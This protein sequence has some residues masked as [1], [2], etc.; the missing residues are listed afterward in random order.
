M[1][2]ITKNSR[3]LS[4]KQGDISNQKSPLWMALWKVHHGAPLSW[5]Y[6]NCH[7]LCAG[8]HIQKGYRAPT[9]D[10]TLPTAELKCESGDILPRI[11]TD[12]RNIAYGKNMKL[13]NT[14]SFQYY[15]YFTSA[16]GGPK[17]AKLEKANLKINWRKDC[18]KNIHKST[19][20]MCCPQ[21]T[22]YG[23]IQLEA[24]TSNYT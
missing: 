13:W 15:C 20:E 17:S 3:V 8:A 21:I 19:W 5:P 23:R 1:G 10:C 18:H 12:Q 6:A 9:N 4:Q 11:E 24:N 14:F 7:P 2:F 16:D 22:L